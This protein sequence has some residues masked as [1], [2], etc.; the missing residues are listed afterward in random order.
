MSN[1]CNDNINIYECDCKSECKCKD[2]FSDSV[3][4][5]NNQDVYRG[6]FNKSATKKKN[7]SIVTRSNTKDTRMDVVRV[8]EGVIDELWKS[9][10]NLTLRQIMAHNASATSNFLDKFIGN[11][12]RNNTQES[13]YDSDSISK[14]YQY[15]MNNI[16]PFFI[17]RFLNK[18]PIFTQ[19][20]KNLIDRLEHELSNGISNYENLIDQSI[21]QSGNYSNLMRN[22][23]MNNTSYFSFGDR[24]SLIDPV[25]VAL[26]GNKLSILEELAINN[27]TLQ[28][29]LSLTK[30]SNDEL[31]TSSVDNFRENLN[32]IKL[33]LKETDMYDKSSNS[34]FK[35]IMV[36]ANLRGA[37][38]DLRNGKFNSKYAVLLNNIINTLQIGYSTFTNEPRGY[39]EAIL[40]LF[41]YKPTTITKGMTPSLPFYYYEYSVNNGDRFSAFHEITN[42]SLQNAQMLAYFSTINGIFINPIVSTPISAYEQLFTGD[43][44]N[45]VFDSVGILVISIDRSNDYNGFGRIIDKDIPVAFDRTLTSIRNKQFDLKS[46]VME[47][48]YPMINGRRNITK[49]IYRYAY[50]KLDNDDWFEYNPYEINKKTI[51]ELHNDDLL[52]YINEITREQYKT[53]RRFISNIDKI[54]G[55]NNNTVTRSRYVT[56]IIEYCASTM[57]AD[58]LPNIID[59]LIS[60]SLLIE[61]NT[62]NTIEL[63]PLTFIPDNILARIRSHHINDHNIGDP[64]IYNAENVRNS[65]LSL[66][67]EFVD[68]GVLDD[69]LK[70]KYLTS[71]IETFDVKQQIYRNIQNTNTIDSIR[72]SKNNKMFM[73]KFSDIYDNITRNSKLLIYSQQNGQILLT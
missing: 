47:S 18:I 24:K 17:N 61:G 60:N 26:F 5:F 63:S 65:L 25:V 38:V 58:K 28:A 45:L 37:I 43:H 15:V 32:L 19:H 46:V 54:N 56:D 35:R 34:E 50:I 69:T 14:I 3:H 23:T 12:I 42:N 41:P 71:N 53:L 8:G 49:R 55:A 51:N 72:I 66:C 59:S 7:K 16:R 20:N 67:D 9:K 73:H 57:C 44:N 21:L 29:T 2:V 52:D 31:T 68:Y 10:N 1:F 36:H 11:Y 30:L 70:N 48:K 62:V 64:N 4:F 33:R 6:G 39:L 27:D 40:R 22:T 13:Y